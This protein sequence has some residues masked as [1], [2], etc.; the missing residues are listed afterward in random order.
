[1]SFESFSRKTDNI[2]R[3][4]K[5]ELHRQKYINNKEFAESVRLRNHARK[6]ETNVIPTWF[7]KELFSRFNGK[8]AY[9][10]REAT[11]IDHVIPL[12]RRGLTE[13]SNL[14]PCCNKCNSSKKDRPLSVFLKYR[15]PVLFD[16]FTD[17]IA[18][19]FENGRFEL[20]YE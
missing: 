18:I 1:L 9:C 7:K 19:A 14:V 13:N 17:T 5:N 12:K 2:C 6:R 8:C 16:A 11:T 10:G 4:C 15:S 3:N 20:L